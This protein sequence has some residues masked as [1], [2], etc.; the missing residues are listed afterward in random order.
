MTPTGITTGALTA[1]SAD[2]NGALDANSA[3]IAGRVNADTFFGGL[4]TRSAKNRFYIDWVNEGGTWKL[5]F[6]IDSQL[7]R[8]W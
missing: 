5:Y 3:N 1:S 4:L 2:I 6:Y 8:T 7:V